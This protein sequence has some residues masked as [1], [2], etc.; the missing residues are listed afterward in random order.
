MALPAEL[1]M[2]ELY[3]FKQ[4]HEKYVDDFISYIN[5]GS[6]NDEARIHNILD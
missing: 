6:I 5:F 1:Q 2:S 3:S 4:D